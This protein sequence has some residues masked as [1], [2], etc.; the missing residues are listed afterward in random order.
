M[1]KKHAFRFTEIQKTNLNHEEFELGF[2]S[3]CSAHSSSSLDNPATFLKPKS[4]KNYD[5]LFGCEQV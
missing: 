5:G 1:L 2:T 3:G 4:G